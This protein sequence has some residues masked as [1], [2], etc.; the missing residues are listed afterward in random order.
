[1]SNF[2]FLNG[3]SQ[4]LIVKAKTD[5]FRVYSQDPAREETS[6]ADVNHDLAWISYGSWTDAARYLDGPVR[7][8]ETKSGR[9]D[10]G[11]SGEGVQLVVRHRPN[12]GDRVLLRGQPRQAI[13][14]MDLDLTRSFI[15]GSSIDPANFELSIGTNDP[16]DDGVDEFMSI[17]HLGP[18]EGSPGDCDTLGIAKWFLEDFQGALSALGALP[19]RSFVATGEV[20][21]NPPRWAFTAT[22]IQNVAIVLFLPGRPPQCPPPSTLRCCSALSG[23]ANRVDGQWVLDVLT[24][25]CRWWCE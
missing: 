15:L 1:M 2:D 21:Q 20:K 6:P 11:P 16:A 13:A 8:L 24:L 19:Q 18:K 5:Y 9:N 23:N 7:W 25:N 3:L 4:G 17:A 12:A 22:D 14:F 10:L